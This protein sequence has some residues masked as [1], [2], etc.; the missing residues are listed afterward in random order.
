MRLREAVG[1]AEELVAMMAPCCLR[2]EV[3]GSVRRDCPEVKDIEVVAVPR[4][5]PRPTSAL[6]LFAGEV[7]QANLLHD[8]AVSEAAAS[9][10][11]RHRLRWIK[12]GTSQLLDWPPKPEGKYWRALVD[13]HVKLD[14]FLATPENYGLILAIRTG[15]A[16]FSQG[17]MAYAK[18]RTAYHV[19]GGYLR[20]RKGTALETSEERDVFDALGLDWVEP[21]ERVGQHMVTRK[22][23]AQFPRK[24]A[25]GAG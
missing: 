18:H 24:E 25:H 9:G 21:K 14:L 15:C 6:P 5:E 17:L 8:W 12:P 20:D 11:S 22:G 13:R 16:E 10:Q 4:W 23:R 19:E 2:V 7:E 3:A 1:I